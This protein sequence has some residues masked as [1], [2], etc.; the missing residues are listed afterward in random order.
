MCCRFSLLM[1]ISPLLPSTETNFVWMSRW[2]LSPARVYFSSLCNNFRGLVATACC[3]FHPM[4]TGNP[5]LIV[6][7][8]PLQSCFIQHDYGV[9]RP[10]DRQA[11]E[12]NV[13]HLPCAGPCFRN[14]LTSW[15]I[16]LVGVYLDRKTGPWRNTPTQSFH[17][18][19]VDRSDSVNRTLLTI[20][21]IIRS[22]A[23]ILLVWVLMLSLIIPAENSSLNITK[24]ILL[25]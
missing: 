12:L 25:L 23:W 20:W 22:P 3:W 8:L 24:S 17:M 2:S 19:L 9:D 1:A 11:C 13:W 7:G 6:G 21:L 16:S 4:I 10:L 18:P 15:L 5:P 14:V